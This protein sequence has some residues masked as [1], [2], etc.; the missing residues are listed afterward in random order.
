MIGKGKAPMNAALWLRVSTTPQDTEKDRV[1]L[2]ALAEGLGVTVGPVYDVHASAWKGDHRAAL[3][4]MFTDAQARKFGVLL[5]TDITRLSREGGIETL[6][7][8]KRLLALGVQVRSIGDPELQGPLDF[9]QRVVTFIKGEVAHEQSNWRSLAIRR[10]LEQA[11]RKGKRLGRPPGR[12]DSPGVQRDSE[13][14]KREQ[15]RRRL[16]G[17]G[18]Y[19][20]GAE[21]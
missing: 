17:E 18:R 19:V 9:G 1:A 5:V 12:K 3:E 4:S 15:A 8:M 6:T 7:I 2:T 21:R 13:S 16:S 10:G 14:L 11:K 20:G